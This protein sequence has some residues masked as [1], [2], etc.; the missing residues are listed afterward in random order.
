MD[1]YKTAQ[2]LWR[3]GVMVIT[4]TPFH[5]TKPDLRFCASSNP[6]RGVS[7]IRDGEDLWEWS[8]LEIRLNAFR[9]STIPQKQV[10]ITGAI[11]K[12]HEYFSFQSK[13]RTLFLK[14]ALIAFEIYGFIWDK[15]FKNGP[16][17]NCERKPLKNLKWYGLLKQ[18]ITSNFLKVVFHKFY[19]IH[20]WILC[21]LFYRVSVCNDIE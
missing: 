9:R 20:S 5:S 21:P 10:I 18:T 4:T 16:S 2:K 1:R 17:K 14:L 15:V 6:A 3:R 11:Q 8:R 7:E 19:L 12:L 13:S